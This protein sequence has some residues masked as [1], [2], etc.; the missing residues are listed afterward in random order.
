[1]TAAAL[2]HHQ[3]LT[4]S[5]CAAPRWHRELQTMGMP[6]E[7]VLRFISGKYEGGLYPLET[8]K[9]IIIGRSMD[10]DMVLLEDTVSR[11]HA[12]LVFQHDA[13]F[14]EDA[15][16]TG[17][18]YVN[19]ARVTQ[20]HRLKIGDRILIGSNIVELV[21]RN[22]VEPDRLPRKMRP[23]TSPPQPTSIMSGLIDEVPL[24]D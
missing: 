8:D 12:R 2:L 6:S 13:L 21:H 3:A 11:R 17:G 14:I 24:P 7:Y 20:R 23:G 15:N 22:E 9:E 16:S 5:S 1:M 19:G 18:T 10:A 4:T